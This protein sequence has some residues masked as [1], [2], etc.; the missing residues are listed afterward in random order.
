MM[1]K[2]L[3]V[4]KLFTENIEILILSIG[5]LSI[6]MIGLIIFNSFEEIF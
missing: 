1:K 5:V 3:S 6:L 4:K 2:L